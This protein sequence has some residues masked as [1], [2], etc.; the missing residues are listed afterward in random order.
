MSTWFAAA[1]IGLIAGLLLYACV[2]VRMHFGPRI[3]EL[4]G[5]SA[6]KAF[7]LVTILA[8]IVIANIGL[9]GV[10]R[11]PGIDNAGPLATEIVYTVTFL[12][13]GAGL[14][15]RRQLSRR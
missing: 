3:R 14:V 9:Y 1:A 13:V 10:R 5:N 8:M 12:V 7:W 2:R 4:Y 6:R 15:F 11:L